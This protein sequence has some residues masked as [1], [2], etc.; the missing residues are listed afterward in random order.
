MRESAF[1]VGEG[2]GVRSLHG[3]GLIRVLL[4]LAALPGPCKLLLGLGCRRLSAYVGSSQFR[5]A[6]LP[7]HCTTFASPICGLGD[8]DL[9]SMQVW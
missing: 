7:L 8:V 2:G 1:V 5:Q 3:V 9:M 4:R 6:A